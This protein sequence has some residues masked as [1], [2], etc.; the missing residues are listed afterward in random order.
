[1]RWDPATARAIGPVLASGDVNWSGQCCWFDREIAFDSACWLEPG[2]QYI[3]VLTVTPWYGQYCC[4]WANMATIYDGA[5]SQG[6]AYYLSNGSNASAWTG[7]TWNNLNQDLIFTIRTTLDCDGNGIVDATEIA[8][9]TAPDCNGNGL[10]DLCEQRPPATAALL[11]TD[12]GP[13]GATASQTQQFDRVIPAG[14][15]VQL[16][17][18][19][20]GDLS[21]T[22]EF[23]LVSLGAG[24]AH[25][26]FTGAEG[27]CSPIEQTIVIPRAEFNDAILKDSLLVNIASSPTVD[28]L[29]CGGSSAVRVELSYTE[30]FP[31]CNDNLVPDYLD[32]CSGVSVDCNANR[33]PDDCDIASGASADIDRDGVP[34]ECQPD[35]NGDQRPDAFQILVGEEPDCNSNGLPDECDLYTSGASVDCNG[36]GVPDECDI[37]A[38]TSP[39]CDA[40]GRIDSC[41]IGAQLVR[42]CNG[43][44]VPDSCDVANGTANDCNA[45]AILDSCE[46]VALGQVNFWT[47][48][49]DM[50]V[51]A[52]YRFEYSDA[53]PSTGSVYCEVQYY[54]YSDG[55]SSRYMQVRLDGQ[56]VHQY[57]DCYWGCCTSNQRGFWVDSQ[58]WN[59][60]AADGDVL[61]EVVT[62]SDC[63][64]SYARL[65]FSYYRLPLS[66][67]CNQNGVPDLCDIDSGF[68][69][70]CNSNGDLD[71]CDIAAG[72][73]D[74]NINGYPDACEL[75]RGD[76]NLDGMVDAEDLAILLTYWGG[77]G[78][79]IGDMNHDG[80]INGADLTVILSNWGQRY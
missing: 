6:S 29:A 3:F 77:V 37:A 18:V 44:G 80:L 53:R 38:G 68:D 4:A 24:P 26:L 42:D 62:Q 32:F 66:E 10:S 78:F 60:F 59:Q 41:A 11:G 27:D 45:N 14:G 61:C 71:G 58:V 54:G 28:A 52:P 5:F 20:S 50:T 69:H 65:Y 76:L 34:D 15:D 75:D 74:D 36:N 70:D 63:N 2:T 22:H 19:A 43:N 17:V 31:D 30:D 57:Y 21:A 23:L 1:M 46:I 64:P 8:N 40:D 13:I 33:N 67:D 48:Q 73:E 56:L 9:G 49:R 55:Y 35:C 51:A 39:D 25:A 47:P 79:P 16:R 72:A 12:L 7:Q